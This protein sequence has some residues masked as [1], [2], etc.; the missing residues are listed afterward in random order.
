MAIADAVTFGCCDFLTQSILVRT[1]DNTYLFHLFILIFKDTPLLDCVGLQHPC[2]DY[3]SHLNI[4]ILRSVNLSSLACLTLTK[5]PLVMWIAA[6]CAQVIVQG[7]ILITTWGSILAVASFTAS[8]TVN[9]LMTGLIVFKIFKVFREVRDVTTSNEKSLGI[10]GGRKLHSIIF[11]IIESGM[12]LFAIQL[13]RL[14]FAATRLGTDA[15]ND[16]YKLVTSI[17]EMLNVVIS[18]VI[19]TLYFY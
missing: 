15:E 19:V 13:A 5:L 8:M 2:R 10:T 11:I 7:Q 18:S 1:T 3:S 17:H 6:I 16:I 4:R 14:V 12:A 9:A